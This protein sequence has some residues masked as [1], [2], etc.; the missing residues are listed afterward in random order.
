MDQETSRDSENGIPQKLKCSMRTSINIVLSAR[1][2]TVCDE[3]IVVLS[4]EAPQQ[5]DRIFNAGH[6]LTL[7]F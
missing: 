3:L 4:S 7:L 5:D 1:I 2:V 6:R